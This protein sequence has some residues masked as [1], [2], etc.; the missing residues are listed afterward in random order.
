ME[1]VI[2]VINNLAYIHENFWFKETLLILQSFIVFALVWWFATLKHGNKLL[3]FLSAIIGCASSIL[4]D[5]GYWNDNDVLKHIAPASL[6]LIGI[7]DKERR[8]GILLFAFLFPFFVI[9]YEPYRSILIALFSILSHFLIYAFIILARKSICL[10]LFFSI[11]IGLLY[12]YIGNI[13]SP[14][15][16]DI[17]VNPVLITLYTRCFDYYTENDKYTLFLKYFW[18]VLLCFAYFGNWIFYF[19]SDYYYLLPF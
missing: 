17:L 10:S 14:G 9:T 2:D 5:L 6:Y 19:L 16:N 7:N 15:T 11:L 1:F 13:A 3:L 18:I 8:N 4:G 12:I